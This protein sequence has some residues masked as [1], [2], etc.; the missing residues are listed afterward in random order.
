MQFAPDWPVIHLL[1][2]ICNLAHDALPLKQEC[3]PHVNELTLM[4]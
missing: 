2:N 4:S 1:C 3:V